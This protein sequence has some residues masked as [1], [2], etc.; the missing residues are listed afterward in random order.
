M[1]I[2]KKLKQIR[3]QKGIY[4][5]E[6][7]EKLG[8]KSNSYISKVENGKFIPSE[9]NLQK[10]GEVLGLTFEDIE[11]LKLEAKLEELGI[12]EPAFTM[13]MKDVPD[14]SHEEK[15]SIIRA[16]QAVLKAREAKRNKVSK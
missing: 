5:E 10:W 4:Q 2:G 14:M 12:S 8:F 9:N 15:Q 16:Y 13:M 11:N 7:A 1:D 6:I 3:L